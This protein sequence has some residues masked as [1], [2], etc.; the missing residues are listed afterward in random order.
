MPTRVCDFHSEFV[1][2]SDGSASLRTSSSKNTR[3]G[4]LEMVSPPVHGE[5]AG[6]S[7]GLSEAADESFIQQIA[8]FQIL[9]KIRQRGIQ[10]PSE[11]VQLDVT[12]VD[13]RMHV[14]PFMRNHDETRAGVGS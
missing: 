10:F 8:L 9:Q 5:R 1:S 6:G 2:D 7:P 13:L 11:L 4:V 12:I 3:K 14:P